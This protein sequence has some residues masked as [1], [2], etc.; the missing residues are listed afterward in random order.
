MKMLH[1]E[2][3][4]LHRMKGMNYIEQID[5]NEEMSPETNVMYENKEPEQEES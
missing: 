3:V 2:N 5:L 4:T 1:L